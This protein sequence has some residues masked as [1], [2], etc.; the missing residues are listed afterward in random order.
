VA[1]TD[2][3]KGGQ[4]AIASPRRLCHIEA[5]K[6]SLKIYNNAHS[7]APPLNIFW[8]RV[9]YTVQHG[10]PTFSNKYDYKLV[11]FLIKRITF[12]LFICFNFIVVKI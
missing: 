9:R 12:I 6:I 10:T 5:D 1:G 7:R 11:P 8:I 3:W 2:P 4:M